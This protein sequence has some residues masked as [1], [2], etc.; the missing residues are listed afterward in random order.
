MLL[1]ALLWSGRLVFGSSPWTPQV[2]SLLA[3]SLLLA[4]A[5]NLV[6]M[7]LSPGRWVR[8]SIA[9]LAGVWAIAATALSVDPLWIIALLSHAGGVGTAWSS[10]LDQWFHQTKPDRVPVRATALALGLVWLPGFVAALAIPSMP[11]TGWILAGLGLAAGWAYARAV[12]GA[13]WIIRVPLPVI[14]V[15]SAVGLSPPAMLGMLAVIAALTFLAW[16]TD[17]HRAAQRPIRKRVDTLTVPPEL[18]PPGLVEA[19]GY[20][21][22]GRPLRSKD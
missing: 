5:L 8:N 3:L 4:N 19:M 1:A 13:L 15:I 17:A 14:G 6:A 9:V 21:R 12:S 10:R 7:L 16:T 18:T 2:A 11:P 20:D 22:K